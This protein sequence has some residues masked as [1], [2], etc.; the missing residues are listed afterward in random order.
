MIFLD[1]AALSD[2]RATLRSQLDTLAAR[3]GRQLFRHHVGSHVRR[4]LAWWPLALPAAPLVVVIVEAGRNL[5]HQPPI[6]FAMSTLLAV[7]LAGPLALAA[8]AAIAAAL[9]YRRDRAAALALFDRELAAWDALRTSDEFLRA[10]SLDAADL[11]ASF[12]RATIAAQSAAVA[13]ALAQPTPELAY[14][15]VPFRRSGLWGVPVAIL[16]FALSLNWPLATSPAQTD[17]PRALAVLAGSS[18]TPV[19]PPKPN[20]AVPIDRKPLAVAPTASAA[21]E[22]AP[23]LAARKDRL[24]SGEP[25][26]G[27]GSQANASDAAASAASQATPQKPAHSES[28]SPKTKPSELAK[29]EARHTPPKPRDT[30]T[31]QLAAQAESGQGRSPS[32]SSN[33]PSPFDQADS[34]DHAGE[35]PDRDLEGESQEDEDEQQKADS[36]AQPMQE[37]R[38]QDVSRALAPGAPGPEESDDPINVRGGPG[39]VKKSRGVPS[40]ILGIP[41]PDRVPGVPGAGR[42]KV[43]QEM[44]QPT[45]ESHAETPA[46]THP[47]RNGPAGVIQQPELSPPRRK[48]LERYFQYPRSGSTSTD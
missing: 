1:S 7:S 6:E 34:P 28:K 22:A 37:Q 39:E 8:I 15:A 35:L 26:A 43:T 19:E 9:R 17:D 20:S 11:Q 36:S 5:A 27:Q 47:P 42:T 46:L 41:V 40:M 18:S 45:P 21:P 30:E 25:S 48:L 24:P 23:P 44:A 38:P 12:M 4:A 14:A 31:A 2:R 29:P 32:S 3:G 10:A 16:L 13:R 33:P